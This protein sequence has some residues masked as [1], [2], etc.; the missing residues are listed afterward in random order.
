METV[1]HV[2]LPDGLWTR[3]LALNDAE[4][5]F[6]LIAAS[7]EADIGEVLI[8]L[9]D[10]QGDWQRPSLDFE[11]DTLA[12]LEGD[13]LLAFA[14]I[15]SRG[16]GEA[17]V[18]PQHRGQGIGTYVLGWMADRMRAVGGSR[19]GQSI[20]ASNVDAVDLMRRHGYEELYTSWIL[21][22]ALDAEISA[23][24]A[25]PEGVVVRP[26]K[27]G[28]ERAAYQVIEDAFNEW[29]NRPPSTYDDWEAVV[30]RRPG[31][32]PWHLLVAA[33]GVELLGVCYL[34]VGDGVVWVD[35]LAVRKDQ[36]GRGLGRALLVAAFREGRSRGAGS[37]QLST[38]SRTGALGVYEHVGMSVT[39][40]FV[41]MSLDLRRN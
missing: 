27:P 8:E 11:R 9:E 28:E 19:V 14:E 33:D 31:F 21:R 24:A 41:H 6:E 26:F 23:D 38:D 30:L 22:L 18:H 2:R 17:T 7:E 20:P 10:I 16:R 36:R 40:T 5:V 29:P 3:P 34:S 32:E 4:A 25:L 15:S 12:V 39:N 1:D 37:A 13:R 35:Q